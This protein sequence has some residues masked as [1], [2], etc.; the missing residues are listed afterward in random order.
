MSE[1]GCWWIPVI[2]LAGAQ[3]G[4]GCND[5]AAKGLLEPDPDTRPLPKLPA[6]QK[7][8]APSL[9]EPGRLESALAELTRAATAG[10]AEESSPS[11]LELRVTEKRVLL[12]AED[13]RSPGRVLQWE[14]SNGKLQRPI[15]VELRGAG[16]LEEN[17][18]SLDGVYLKAIPRLC[19][20]AV[21]HVDPQDGKVTSIVVRRNFPYSQ[22]VRFRVFV[23]SP[24]RSGQL[25]ANRFGHPLLG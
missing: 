6:P 4:L 15:P 24:R 1:S 21:E 11:V 13:H 2:V 5:L 22:D 18:Y 16:E 20:L 25:D 7:L 23:D 9:L 10:A 14:Y 19:T 12:Q 3:L 8:D 17:L